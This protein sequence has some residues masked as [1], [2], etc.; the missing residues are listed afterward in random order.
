MDSHNVDYAIRWITS[1]V[2][3]RDP[4]FPSRKQDDEWAHLFRDGS[5]PRIS[6]DWEEIDPS[7]IPPTKDMEGYILVVKTQTEEL[8]VALNDCDVGKTPVLPELSD[9]AELYRLE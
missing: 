9:G 5:D 1:W 6:D 2:T 3:G 7:T 4:S 8:I